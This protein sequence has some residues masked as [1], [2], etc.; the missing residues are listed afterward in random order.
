MAPH[1]LFWNIFGST[2]VVAAQGSMTDF[3]EFQKGRQ[4]DAGG[5]EGQR[6]MSHRKK[7][8]SVSAAPLCWWFNLRVRR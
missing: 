4:F 7:G 6:R 1:K 2:G 8:R 5:E 3:Y